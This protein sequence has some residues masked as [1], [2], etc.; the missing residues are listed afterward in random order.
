M[1]CDVLLV[2][3]GR[4]PYTAN[5]GLE[6]MGISLDE[7]GRVSVDSHFKTSV[8]KS[9][10]LTDITLCCVNVSVT[11]PQISI[12]A[13]GDCIHGPMLAHKAEDEG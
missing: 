3:I 8:P 2:C 12:Y 9:V 13:I 7:R 10:P 11:V 4:R 1:S 6:N 5:L